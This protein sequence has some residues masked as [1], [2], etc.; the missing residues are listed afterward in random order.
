[1]PEQFKADCTV[2]GHR[3]LAHIVEQVFDDQ[4][5]VWYGALDLPSV[6]NVYEFCQRQYDLRLD[7]GRSMTIF[8]VSYHE[9]FGGSEPSKVQ[10]FYFV[11]LG[12]LENPI[13]EILKLPKR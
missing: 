3:G 6:S 1:M 4:F 2:N 5:K 8:V 11:S 9:D 13:D 10:L 12:N 7:D